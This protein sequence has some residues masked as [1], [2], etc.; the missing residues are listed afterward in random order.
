MQ[1]GTERR[2]HLC[3]ESPLDGFQGPGAFR[4]QIEQDRL[5]IDAPK[6]RLCP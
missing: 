5:E 6:K 4:A 3:Q 2:G 1:Q